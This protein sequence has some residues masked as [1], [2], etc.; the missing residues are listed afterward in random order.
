M[1]KF[2]QAY[3]NVVKKKGQEMKLPGL[4]YTPDQLFFIGAS[5]VQHATPIN[6]S[7]AMCCLFDLFRL[8]VMKQRLNSW[9]DY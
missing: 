6:H 4:P 9:A 1:C 8:C 3:K 7:E 2:V 5:Q